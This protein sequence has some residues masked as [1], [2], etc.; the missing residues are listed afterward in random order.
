MAHSAFR[1]ALLLLTV[2]AAG[3]CDEPASSSS[4][5]G[6]GTAPSAAADVTGTWAGSAIDSAG[7]VEMSWAITQNGRTITGTVTGTTNVGRPV[8]TGSVT[9]TQSS[10]TLRFTVAVPAGRIADLP[11]CSLQ[12]TGALT[13]IQAGS[14][15]GTYTGSHSCFGP[16]DAGRILLIRQ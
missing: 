2:L 5:A 11:D 1:A 15:A 4:I 8:Y 13:D 9:G 14:M 10:G 6:L 7:R 16:V 12:L 3:S